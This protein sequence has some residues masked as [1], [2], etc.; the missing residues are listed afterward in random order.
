MFTLTKESELQYIIRKTGRKPIQCKCMKCKN[1]CHTTCIGT[2]GD[3]LRLI[4]A[5][6]ADRLLPTE[7]AA[8]MVMVV[9]DHSIWMVQAKDNGDW[10]TF[11]HDGLCELHDKGLKPTEGKLSHHSIAIDNFT[12]KKSISWNVAKTW[13][14]ERNQQVIQEILDELGKLNND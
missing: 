12:P 11:Y 7:W 9:T 8:G 2:P 5:G 4:K 10:C 3:I 13:E 1:Q 6:Y 14:D